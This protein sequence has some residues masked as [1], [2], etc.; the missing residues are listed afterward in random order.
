MQIFTKL[1][2]RSKAK[3]GRDCNANLWSQWVSDPKAI[4]YLLR[5][6]DALQPEEVSLIE[7]WATKQLEWGLHVRVHGGASGMP[8]VVEVFGP[9]LVEPHVLSYRVGKEIQVDEAHGKSRRCSS[10][11]EA[12]DFIVQYT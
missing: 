9:N 11:V 3:A 4:H 6:E 5:D 8:Q 12:L 10:V 2:A 1:T 7:D